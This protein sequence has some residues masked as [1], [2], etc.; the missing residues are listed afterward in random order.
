MVFGGCKDPR[1]DPALLGHAHAL[2]G[3]EG[4][5]VPGFDLRHA[6]PPVALR[7]AIIAERAIRTLAAESMP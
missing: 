4:L 5:D 3:A 1:D 7:R 6:R 2:L